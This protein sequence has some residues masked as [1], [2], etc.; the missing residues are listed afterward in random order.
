MR[1]PFMIS[2]FFYPEASEQQIKADELRTSPKPQTAFTDA[3]IAP[4]VSEPVSAPP[5]VPVTQPAPAPAPTPSP[6][7]ERAKSF[8][9]DTSGYASD[10]DLGGAI[11]SQLQS[12]AM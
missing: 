12:V 7:F 1:L 8:G 4:P 11:L 2:A 9:F 5:P 6:L 10:A 3:A